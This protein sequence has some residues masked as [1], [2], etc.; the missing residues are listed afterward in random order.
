MLSAA[1]VSV[2]V[3]DFVVKPLDVEIRNVRYYTDSKVDLGY[4]FY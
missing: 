2:E 1:V 3:A 4:I